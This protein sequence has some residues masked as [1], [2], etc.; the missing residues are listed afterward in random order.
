MGS[1][2]GI[3]SPWRARY[4]RC[5]ATVNSYLHRLPCYDQLSQWGQNY[6]HLSKLPSLS[7]SARSHILPSMDIGSFEPI[8]TLRTCDVVHYAFFLKLYLVPWKKATDWLKLVEQGVILPLL[9]RLDKE[10]DAGCRRATGRFC[11]LSAGCCCRTKIGR[12]TTDFGLIGLS[13]WWCQR[14]YLGSS[15][16]SESNSF[17]LWLSATSLQ[18]TKTPVLSRYP[19]PS[20]SDNSHTWLGRIIYPCAH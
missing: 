18:A 20:G 13:S 17:E 15:R 14:Q 1:W 11:H 4:T 8:I 10:V 6:D 7:W 2:S 5:I 9:I 3:M 16:D 19:R 12:R